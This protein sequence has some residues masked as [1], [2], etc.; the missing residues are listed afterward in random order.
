MKQTRVLIDTLKRVL[1][2]EKITYAN[3]AV[4]LDLSEASVKRMFARLNFTLERLERICDLAGLPLSELVRLADDRPEPITMLNPEQEHELLADRKLLLVAFLVLNH[5]SAAQIVAT[6]QIDEYEVIRK[7]AKLD[8]L[9]MIELLPGNRVRRLVARNFN[10]RKHG[11]VQRFFE[12]EVKKDFLASRFAGDG[13]HLRFIGG[14]IS[15]QSLSRMRQAIDRVTREFDEMVQVDADLPHG[16]KVG[17][18]AVLAI[19]PWEVPSF[20]ALRRRAP[21]PE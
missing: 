4:A 10:W 5:W 17:V 18:G 8:R 21:P 14:M 3:I 13:E 20:T 6:F 1:R 19:R 9:G 15:R 11:P 2:S 12:Q 16:E 7:L